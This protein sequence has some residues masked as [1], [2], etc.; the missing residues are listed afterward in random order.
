MSSRVCMMIGRAA[1]TLPSVEEWA[2]RWK[3]L[4]R[5]M[6]LLLTCELEKDWGVLNYGPNQRLFTEWY[7]TITSTKAIRGAIGGVVNWTSQRDAL[8]WSLVELETRG[9]GHKIPL[10]KAW[11]RA[12]VWR[13]WP[14]SKSRSRCLYC[15]FGMEKMMC[16]FNERGSVKTVGPRRFITL[17]FWTTSVNASGYSGGLE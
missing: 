10:Q 1:G 3:V 14:F 13:S 11:N 6:L 16:L 17:K 12:C 15:F 9:A 4:H 2:K 5:Q 7:Q 8:S